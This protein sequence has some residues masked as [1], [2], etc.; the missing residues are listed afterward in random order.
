MGKMDAEIRDSWVVS[1]DCG[2]GESIVP[3]CCGG[4]IGD[5]GGGF[6]SGWGVWA[7]WDE[8]QTGAVAQMLAVAR[9]QAHAVCGE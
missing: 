2:G 8:V 7:W 1:D 6:R 9:L 4:M 3:W 5:L